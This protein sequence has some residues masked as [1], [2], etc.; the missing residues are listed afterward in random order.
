MKKNDKAF[1]FLL[2]LVT[3]IIWKGVARYQCLQKSFLT[4]LHNQR[5]NTILLPVN[6]ANQCQV[7]PAPFFPRKGEAI[8]EWRAECLVECFTVRLD[9]DLAKVIVFL[10]GFAINHHASSLLVRPPDGIPRC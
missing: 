6:I 3:W 4:I 7:K 5:V 1:S 9:A 10:K 2:H 8:H